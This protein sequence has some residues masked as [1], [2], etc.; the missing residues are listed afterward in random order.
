MLSALNACMTGLTA[1][2]SAAESERSVRAQWLCSSNAAPHVS[3][4]ARSKRGSDVQVHMAALSALP[5]NRLD[6]N[7]AN[8]ESTP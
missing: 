8:D 6:A 4:H 1:L 5:R 7:A 2:Q 3:A